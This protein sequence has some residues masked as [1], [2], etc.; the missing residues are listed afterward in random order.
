MWGFGGPEG[1][2]TSSVCVGWSGM[3]AARSR[4]AR[5]YSA[6]KGRR[7]PRCAASAGLKARAA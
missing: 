3:L 2:T 6:V 5:V 7:A 1:G 4:L